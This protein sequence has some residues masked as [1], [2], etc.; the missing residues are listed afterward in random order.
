MLT[1]L[2][3][4]R[5]T[6]PRDLVDLLGECHQRIRHFVALA[7]RVGSLQNVP[8]DETARACMEVERYF[9]RALPLHVADEEESIEPRLRGLSAT[10]DEALDVM[11][12]QHRQ[13]DP[14]LKALLR[15]TSALRNSPQ[16]KM[17]GRELA[18]AALALEI[19]FEEH[20]HLE[21]SVIFPAIRQ[22][23]SHEVQTSISEELR[24]RRHFSRPQ[25]GPMPPPTQ[26]DES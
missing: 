12:R 23:L 10:V 8:P 21:E 9:T 14:L 1:Q 18:A 6:A 16:D 24:S 5:A 7:R 13:H 2:S 17:A 4:H 26:E 11:A 22:L 25:P 20:L 15:A 3:I 19:Q